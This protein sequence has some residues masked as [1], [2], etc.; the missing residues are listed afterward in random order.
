MSFTDFKIETIND[1]LPEEFYNLIEKNTAYIANTFPFTLTNC[2]DLEKQ[3]NLS[4]SVETRKLIKKTII[5]M[6]EI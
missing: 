1:I 5:F 3:N 4:P 6:P 2:L